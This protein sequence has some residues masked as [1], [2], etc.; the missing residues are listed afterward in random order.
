[1]GAY[2]TY[3]W[4]E[5]KVLVHVN[6]VA[7]GVKCGCIC[8]HCKSPLYAK[9]GG[10]IREH[11]FAH[12][13][14]HECDGA[15][16]TTLHLLAK[17]VLQETG[18]I[19]LPPSDRNGFP[20]G[21]VRLQNIEVEKWDEENR[22]RPDVEGIMENG[23]RLLI[24]FLVSHKVDEK[25][26]QTIIDRN[27]KCVEIDIKYQSLQKTEFRDFLINSKEDREWIVTMPKP[28][29]PS[30]SSYS[31]YTRDPFYD[32]I[33]D[34]L[35]KEFDEKTIRIC[36]IDEY[37]YTVNRIYDRVYDLKKLGYDVC[38]VGTK[39]RGFKTD[40]LLYRSKKDDKG[41]ISINIRGR[42]RSI[43][44][45]HPHGLRI[46]DIVVKYGM[47]IEDILT[48]L[49]GGNV[50]GVYWEPVHYYEFRYLY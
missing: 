13:Q 38:E 36:P 14:G 9:N 30:E 7:K 31:T 10:L 28:N 2:L 45:R 20:V 5:N 16:E 22:I 4:D 18:S 11:H 21:L 15:F 1:M 43:G 39:F 49:K 40:L 50:S 37:R 23:E 35:K 33:R 46:I 24:E 3:A 41:Y 32:E 47:S 29:P 12:A 27:L 44:F 8:P 17:E 42:R 6:D 19:L 48:L 26:R 34:F 25:K